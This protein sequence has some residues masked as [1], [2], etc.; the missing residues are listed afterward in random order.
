MRSQIIKPTEEKIG[1]YH[2]VLEFGSGFLL[3]PKAQARLSCCGTCWQSQA[4]CPSSVPKCN[5]EYQVAYETRH[6]IAAI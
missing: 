5:D 4:A 2:H 6:C 1:V 3:T